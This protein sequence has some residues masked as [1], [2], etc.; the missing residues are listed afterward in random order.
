MNDGL[1]GARAIAWGCA[2]IALTLLVAAFV[3]ALR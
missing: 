1:N 3:L 2:L